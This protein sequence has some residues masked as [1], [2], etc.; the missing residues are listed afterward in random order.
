MYHTDLCHF[1][2]CK[3]RAQEYS[4]EKQTVSNAL[5]N[6]FIENDFLQTNNEME[7]ILMHGILKES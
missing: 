2:S 1:L 6:V 7:S 3:I 5:W 4:L